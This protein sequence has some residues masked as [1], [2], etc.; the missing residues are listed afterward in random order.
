MGATMAD[1][2][3]QDLIST[4]LEPWF[5]DAPEP[6]PDDVVQGAKAAAARAVD[7]VLKAGDLPLDKGATV[8]IVNPSTADTRAVRNYLSAFF[9]D[10][11]V[12]AAILKKV[13]AD[14]YELQ[15]DIVITVDDNKK[16]LVPPN[17]IATIELV[18]GHRVAVDMSY[19]DARR[20][21]WDVVSREA[22]NPPGST[23]DHPGG[24]G[25]PAEAPGPGR[26]GRARRTDLGQLRNRGAGLLRQDPQLRSTRQVGQL[27]DRWRQ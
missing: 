11:P 25:N 2:G 10:A 27:H 20:L 18:E 3:Y 12:L 26:A 5:R 13:T 21:I 24:A 19:F 7:A 17:C 4:I 23:K 8:R 22:E 14:S 9:T 1:D 16:R 15:G 6:R